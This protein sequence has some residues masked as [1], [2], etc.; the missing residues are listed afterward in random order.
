M[1]SFLDYLDVDKP[2]SSDETHNIP[3]NDKQ[4]STVLHYARNIQYQKSMQEKVLDLIVNVIDL[5]SRSNA[6]PAQPSPSDATLFKQALALLQPKDF[7]DVVLERNI[8]GKCAY[9]LCPRP[10][11]DQDKGLRDQIFR[12][13]RGGGNFKLNTKEELGKWC[14]VECAERALFV[15]LQLGI[16]PAWLRSSP[17]DDIKLLDEA[18]EQTAGE[19]LTS[20]MG[21]LAL[22]G[23]PPVDLAAS[24]QELAL[25]QS[26]K[27]TIQERMQAL[28]LERGEENIRDSNDVIFSSILEKDTS[29]VPLAP[30]PSVDGN[31]MVEG[32]R[33]KNF[34]S[35][36][37]CGGKDT[38]KDKGM[39]W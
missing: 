8:Y 37:E 21:A 5:P 35:D 25:D 9:G 27:N 32:Y 1:S 18:G 17:V 13:T 26:K 24:L 39:T 3:V 16:G 28:S 29:S 31:D 36:R 23:P 11:L 6:D 12:I 15:R 33:P 19:D 20:T 14:S 30:Q 38:G 34:H 4:K 2:P 22:N 7:N 10:N